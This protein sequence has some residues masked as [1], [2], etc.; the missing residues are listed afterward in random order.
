[1]KYILQIFTGPWHAANTVAEDVVKR[2][3]SIAS[4][5]QVEKVIIGWNTDQDLYR[6]VGNY[7]HGRGIGMLLW[8][9][10]FSEIRWFRRSIR[11][12]KI[13]CSAV[14]RPAAICKS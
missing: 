6:S 12:G 11:R 13:F 3:E 5:I 8:L 2:I 1:M 14:P 10:V 4:R 9:P 7:L